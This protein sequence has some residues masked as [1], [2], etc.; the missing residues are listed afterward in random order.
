MAFHPPCFLWVVSD[1]VGADKSCFSSSCLFSAV[2]D[3][4]FEE[5][6]MGEKKP[7][8]Q[9]TSQEELSPSSYSVTPR[10]IS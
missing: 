3:D 1:D 9:Q 6:E 8:R 7:L 4:D 5:E 10:L 2:G